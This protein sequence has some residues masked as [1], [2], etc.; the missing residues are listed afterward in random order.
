MLVVDSKDKEKLPEAAQI[1]YDVLSD[2]DVIADRTPI[3]IA[4]NKQ[5]LPFS[6]RARIIERDLLQEIE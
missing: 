1:L 3:I 2:V 4:C 5:D 6:R